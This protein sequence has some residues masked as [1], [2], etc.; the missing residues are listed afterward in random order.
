MIADTLMRELHR[1]DMGVIRPRGAWR[2]VH[3]GQELLRP[4]MGACS[5]RA[6][7]MGLPKQVG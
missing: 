3:F 1:P 5:P 2:A 7:R 4:E 6:R